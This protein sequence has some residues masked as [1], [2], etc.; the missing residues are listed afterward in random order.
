MASHPSAD[1]DS[2]AS[3]LSISLI[4]I[5]SSGKPACFIAKEGLDLAAKPIFQEM[6]SKGYIEECP[7]IFTT[8]DWI[9][10]LVDTPSCSRSRIE[11]GA[12]EKTY[13]VDHHISL[14]AQAG[15]RGVIEG[16]ASSATELCVIM[17]EELSI[18]KIPGDAA[19]MILAGILYDTR[20]LSIASIT[21]IEATRFLVIRG[22]RIQD[23]LKLIRRSLGIDEKIARLKSMARLTA[24]RSEKDVLVCITHVGAYE[25]SAAQ[26]LM[27]A[28]CDLALVLSEK[29]DLVRIVAR[30]SEELCREKGL[31][32]LV[33]EDLTK[34][35]QGGWGGHKLAAAA[36]LKTR[37]ND[38]I[39]EIPQIL[40]RKIGKLSP[41]NP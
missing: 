5:R 8:K 9:L 14:E 35:H 20:A 25:A 12:F 13:I 39:K 4:S 23:A 7:E 11:C 29:E 30:C 3:A 24:Y 22:A 27:G 37:L 33:L 19:N 34:I 17:L 31:G 6:L 41:I 18:D 10:V 28:G 40:E 38:L 21:A 15:V 16:E 2:I 1:P 36:S 26:I 32:E